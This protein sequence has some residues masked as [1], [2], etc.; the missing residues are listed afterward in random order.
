M[1]YGTPPPPPQDPGYGQPAGYGAQ[2]QKNSAMAVTGLVLGIIGAIPCFWG[3]LI[4]SIGG[5][6]FSKL[7]SKD[8]RE[9]NGAKKGEG[10]AK[11]GF[12]LG[13]VGLALGVLYWIGVGTGVIDIT[14]S[15]EM[16]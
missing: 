12:I 9:S 15:G 3:C 1:S 16:N 11:W 8:I 2:P 13:I 5:I 10:A 14:Y 6:V 4:F 7:G